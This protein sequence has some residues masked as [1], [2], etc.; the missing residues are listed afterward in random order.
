VIKHIP[1]NSPEFEKVIK[2]DAR[3]LLPKCFGGRIDDPS[4]LVGKIGPGVVV[5]YIRE[6]LIGI[7]IINDDFNDNKQLKWYGGTSNKPNM[8]DKYKKHYKKVKEIHSREPQYELENNTE[9]L[10]KCY[11]SISVLCIHD[12]Y[13]N[14]KIGSKMLD[15][16]KQLGRDNGFN[17]IFTILST[18]LVGRSSKVENKLL[19]FFNKNG[20]YSRFDNAEVDTFH[21]TYDEE[22]DDLIT[23]RAPEDYIL[24][25]YL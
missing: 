24:K 7:I 22:D 5:S 8:L 13:W 19:P 15:Y 6:K 4:Y 23:P 1:W 3:K 21:T 18:D 25:C 11:F 10:E 12:D 2:H 20:F 16:V 14:K 17:C 9:E